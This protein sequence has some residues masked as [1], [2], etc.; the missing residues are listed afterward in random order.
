[1]P[2]AQRIF[3]TRP[4]FSVPQMQKRALKGMGI[5]LVLV[6]G[7]YVGAHVLRFGGFPSSLILTLGAYLLPIVGI[8]KLL[9]FHQ[10]RLYEGL[11]KYAGTPEAVRL[12]Q[13]TSI[14][15]GSLVLGL[16]VLPNA[17]PVPIALLVLDWLLTTATMGARRFGRRALH[18]DWA[19]SPSPSQQR[20]LI[21]GADD[22]GVFL[23]RYL[24]NLGPSHGTVVGF[25]DPAH[26]GLQ[27][28]GLPIVKSPEAL[29][30]NEMIVPV[31]LSTS[32]VPLNRDHTQIFD[33]YSSTKV[34]CHQFEITMCPTSAACPEKTAVDSLSPTELSEPN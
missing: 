11:W 1:M 4:T 24:R 10:F 31:S 8:L 25:V 23:L 28:Q 12:V 26:S 18:R 29:D 30:A 17:G 27:L 33:R 7:S 32:G 6:F 19:P 9:I 3:P 14:A 2:L 16:A 5:D 13:A 22:Y 34:A 21:Y 20:I 15:S